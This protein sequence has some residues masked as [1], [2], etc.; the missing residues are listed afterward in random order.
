[1]KI[2]FVSNLYPPN[3][4]GGAEIVVEKMALAIQERGHESVIITTSPMRMNT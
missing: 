1:M 4:L 3:V 2:C